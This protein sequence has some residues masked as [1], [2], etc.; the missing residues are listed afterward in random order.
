MSNM[1]SV[2]LENHSAFVSRFNCL[3]RWV[4]GK[5]E[6]PNERRYWWPLLLINPKQEGL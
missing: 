6:D 4:R 5:P 2:K 3:S 1:T